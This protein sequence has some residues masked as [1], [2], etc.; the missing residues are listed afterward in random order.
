[1]N[2]SHARKGIRQKWKQMQKA[3]GLSH[4]IVPLICAV[5]VVVVVVVFAAAAAVIIAG[6]DVELRLLIN[7]YAVT[8]AHWQ[9]MQPAAETAFWSTHTRPS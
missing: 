4:S 5:L 3:C 6:V 9:F 1:M 8:F 7:S 2:I